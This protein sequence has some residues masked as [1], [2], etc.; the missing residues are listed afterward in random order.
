M[1][2]S[3]RL[4]P[5]NLP[6]STRLASILAMITIMTTETIILVIDITLNNNQSNCHQK[7]PLPK[8]HL[9]I[10]ATQLFKF[11]IKCFQ[12]THC[13]WLKLLIKK[14][15]QTENKLKFRD[16]L[17]FSV[18]ILREDSQ[19][20]QSSRFSST[21]SKI[22]HIRVCIAQSYILG[23]IRDFELMEG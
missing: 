18:E 13:V 19:R 12:D 21:S 22:H 16:S 8:H 23:K 15:M 17:G 7:L 1:K 20:M 3:Q 5:Q 9:F 14:Y 11:L 6:L 2:V 4:L 10:Y